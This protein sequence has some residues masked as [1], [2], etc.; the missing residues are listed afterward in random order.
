MKIQSISQLDNIIFY[1]N[2]SDNSLLSSSTDNIYDGSNVP[3]S[4]KVYMEVAYKNQSCKLDLQELINWVNARI[5]DLSSTVRDL[6]VHLSG[7]TITGNLTVNG[8]LRSNNLT[9]NNN[10]SV[11]NIA[12]KNLSVTTNATLNNL[13]VNNATII[14]KTK[15][16]EL[17]CTKNPAQLTAYA[18]QW[19]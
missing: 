4:D 17:T 12:T 19:R 10:L 18:A 16:Q 2:S 13:S 8:D 7:D 11:N 1:N 3:V 9:V 15:T 6:Y 5:Q 14:Y